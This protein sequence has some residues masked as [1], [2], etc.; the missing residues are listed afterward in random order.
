MYRQFTHGN[1]TSLQLVVPHKFRDKV[2]KLAHQSLMVGHL[3]LENN[4]HSLS[5]LY[6]PG[7][8][9]EVS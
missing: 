8:F 4:G 6:W 7:V 1:K 3:V 5:E 2:L 9:G